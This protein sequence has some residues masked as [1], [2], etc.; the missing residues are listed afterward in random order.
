VRTL[1]HVW[2]VACLVAGCDDGD[3]L[4]LCGQIPTDGCPIGRGGT[5][6][7]QY[8]AALYDC[9]QGDWTLV[10]PCPGFGQGGGGS[11]GGGGAGG[12]GGECEPASF[13]HSGETVGCTPDLQHPDCPLAA[14]EVC[15]ITACLTDCLDFY[16]CTDRG[17]A[18]RALCTDEGDL[19]AAPSR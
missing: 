3:E 8:C 14:A 1:S 19:V 16:L 4:L 13:D 15:P 18:L 9:V 12:Q 5:C 17:W 10:E 2:L 6:E 7:D 11:G